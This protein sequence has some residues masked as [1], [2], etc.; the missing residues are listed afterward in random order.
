VAA[1]LVPYTLTLVVFRTS[2]LTAGAKMFAG[3]FANH[4]GRP[5][6]LAP[7]SLYV[8]AAAVFVGHAIAA[9]PRWPRLAEALPSPVRGLGYAA[10]VTAAFLL[11]PDAGQAFVY[12]Q[13]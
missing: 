9:H 10:A 4:P 12:F 3:M 8:L 11:A 6:P 2:S 5:L 7:V 13:F 1:F